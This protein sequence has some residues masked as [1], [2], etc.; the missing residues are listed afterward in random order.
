MGRGAAS[1]HEPVPVIR[2]NQ[3]RRPLESVH[4]QFVIDATGQVLSAEALDSPHFASQAV[5]VVETLGADARN[6]RVLM[7]A[8][9]SGSSSV[10]S[11]VLQ[12]GADAKANVP[13]IKFLLFSAVSWGGGRTAED[14]D[15]L[16]GRLVSRFLACVF[17]R[18]NA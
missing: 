11:R 13:G 9:R 6:P 12:A 3:S 15:T 7:E 5:S 16:T 2:T 1:P 14:V 4:V 8:A 18:E 17:F 10:V